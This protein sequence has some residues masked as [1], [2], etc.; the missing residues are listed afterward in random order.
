MTA[1]DC[2]EDMGRVV[3]FK[4]M[5]KLLVS[6]GL[7]CVCAL[8]LNASGA[9][10]GGAER[11]DVPI[12]DTIPWFS[13]RGAEQMVRADQ[14]AYFQHLQR[15]RTTN[16][17][18]YGQRLHKAMMVIALRDADPAMY[19]AW[20]NLWS[21]ERRYIARADALVRASVVASQAGQSLDAAELLAAQQELRALSVE[22]EQASLAM[23]KTK[24]VVF[25]ERL[26]NLNLTIADLRVNV[27]SYAEER[28]MST[29]VKIP[30]PVAGGQ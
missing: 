16:P 12:R 4:G 13:Q 23:L 15:L 5:K 8:P 9:G 19:A 29:M 14:P 26:E 28:V 22:W 25:A 21:I 24:S 11:D 27:D 18:K 20:V 10:F 30:Q 1:R 7:L 3:T 2:V 17:Q 6:L